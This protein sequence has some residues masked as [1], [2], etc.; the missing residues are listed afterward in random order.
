MDAPVVYVVDDDVPLRQSMEQLFRSVS[1]DFEAYSSADEFLQHFQASRP[2]CLILDLRLPGLTGI[3][4]QEQLHSLGI[5]V[6]IIFL[7]G[8]ADV[9]SAVR[10]MRGGALDFIQKPHDP[11]EL[12]SKVRYAI[13]ISRERIEKTAKD[14]IIRDCVSALTAREREV[15][16][17][18][19][20][21]RANREIAE[22][23][24]VSCKTVEFHRSRVMKKMRADSLAH[25]VCAAVQI[26]LCKMEY[27]MA[28]A[29]GSNGTV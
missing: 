25:L 3:E 1:I 10:A 16:E 7:T 29:N 5:D 27:P 21:G 9:A 23:L 15:M 2:G 8:F 22:E 20:G 11:T 12:L 24:G 28:H 14:R 4:F 19:V 17:R 26:G 6:P 13:D 18:V